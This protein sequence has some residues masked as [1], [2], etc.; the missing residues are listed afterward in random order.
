MLS[1]LDVDLPHTLISVR[2]HPKGVFSVKRQSF[3]LG[4]F[5]QIERCMSEVFEFDLFEKCARGRAMA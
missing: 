3:W 2:D 4:V 5:G 1:A